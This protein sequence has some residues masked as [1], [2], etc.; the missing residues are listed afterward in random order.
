MVRRSKEMMTM[1][2]LVL[3]ATGGTGIAIVK[4]A[5]SAGHEVV[6]VVRDEKTL[7]AALQGAAREHSSTH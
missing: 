6:A 5:Q 3:G 1:K 2:I 4:E 7:E